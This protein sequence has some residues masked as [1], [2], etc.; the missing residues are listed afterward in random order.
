MN[1][2]LKLKNRKIKKSKSVF[3]QILLVTSIQ[4]L[5]FI[6]PAF[7]NSTLAINKMRGPTQDFNKPRTSSPYQTSVVKWVWKGAIRLY[8]KVISPA[9]GPRSPSYPTGSAY[10]R[11][12]I[13]RYGFLMGVLL[14]GDRL[15]HEADIHR[16]QKIFIFNRTRY[17]DPIEY[18]TYWW[19]KSVTD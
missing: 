14:I 15:F 19:D 11:V 8:S 4:I 7:F 5:F 1:S 17:F 3:C 10:G 6:T 12:A 2:N 9:D 13:E 16:G 18:N